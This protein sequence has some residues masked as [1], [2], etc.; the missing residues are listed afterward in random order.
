MEIRSW[1]HQSFEASK[2]DGMLALAIEVYRKIT[3][4][5]V[6]KDRVQLNYVKLENS[7]VSFDWKSK[8]KRLIRAPYIPWILFN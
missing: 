6:L 2:E 5:L 4:C 1:T 8:V 7:Q 3:E